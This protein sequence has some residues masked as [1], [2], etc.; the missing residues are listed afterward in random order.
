MKSESDSDVSPDDGMPVLIEASDSFDSVEEYNSHWI[1]RLQILGF[2]N[3]LQAKVLSLKPTNRK[4]IC[5]DGG[6]TVHI[7]NDARTCFDAGTSNMEVMGVL[8]KPVPCSGKG[9]LHLQPHG[10]LSK[11]ILTGAHIAKDFPFSFISESMLTK[12]GC[13]IIKKD[14]SALVLDAEGN[15]LFRASLKD[16]L[17]FVDG[18][19]LLCPIY[20]QFLVSD[21]VG[22]SHHGHEEKKIDLNAPIQINLSR[23]YASKAQDDLLM[24]AHRRHS[25]MDLLRCAKAAGITLPP[26]YVLP[27]CDSCVLGKSEDHPHHKGANVK[28]HRRCQAIHFDFCGP[29]PT[30]GIYGERY[31]LIFIDG[32]T[33]YV[34]DFY[35]KSQT[36]F[37]VILEALLL[38]LDNEFG[39]HCV[40]ILRSD[41]AKVFKES[42]VQLR[43]VQ[44]ARNCSAVFC[45]IQSVAEWKG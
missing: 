13:T 31:I 6:A 26:G 27:I 20:P 8:G 39:H 11:L 43:A 30:T 1:T 45:P 21:V 19:L 12:K 7:A 33:G 24:L 28:P 15:A 37:F 4:L 35:P 36:E 42:P 25:H 18:Q 44:V 3:M 2:A 10:D 16:D 23:S 38:R 29:F 5:L 41:N 14:H 40:S 22:L 9:N 34:W 32:F 17:F